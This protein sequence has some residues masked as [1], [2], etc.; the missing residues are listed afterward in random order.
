MRKLLAVAV[1]LAVVAGAMAAPP[2]PSTL[3][4]KAEVGKPALLT[5]KVPDGKKLGTEKTFDPQSL[6][7]ARLWTDDASV[8]EFWVFPNEA[9]TYRVPFWTEG[10]TKGVVVKVVAGKGTTTPPPPVTDPPDTDPPAK[11]KFY[12]AVVRP[13]GPVSKATADAL[14][15]SAW[16]EL[17]SAGHQ[18]R[19]FG[20][21]ELPAGVTA[22]AT[23]PAVV[24]LALNTDGK[25]WTPQPGSKP[26]PTTDA[27]VRDLLPKK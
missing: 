7:L 15:L 24:T 4:L 16:D 9:G 12:F 6:M 22:P 23:L 26:L 8:Y 3:E 19:D 11:A 21:D 27:G 1:A 2:L 17:R 14:R 20:T 18:M 25:T 10:D 5:L 13:A